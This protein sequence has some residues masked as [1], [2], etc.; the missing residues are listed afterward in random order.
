[1]FQDFLKLWGVKHR[2]SSVALLQSNGRV[3]AAVRAAE[4]IIHNNISPDGSLDNDKAAWEI[5]QYQNTP[6]ID[7]N[8][9]L[10][11]VLLHRQL[12]ESI[13]AHHAHYCPHKE[14]VLT[15][16]ERN[17]HLSKWNH[18]LLQ[19]HD[20]KAH[21]LIPLTLG[22]NVMVQGKEGKKWDR[23]GHIVEVFPNRQYSIRMFHSR[24]GLSAT[25]IC[26]GNTWQLCQRSPA[27]PFCI[28]PRFKTS[29]CH[30]M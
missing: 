18:I 5:L 8:L 27:N 7:I 28:T 23:M 14:W 3:E 13:P 12:Q 4:R 17:L 20:A 9:S 21:E 26:L 1:M 25:A 2:L 10:A 30:S 6:L 29:C 15:A 22:T 11:Q 16:E 24:R 19:K